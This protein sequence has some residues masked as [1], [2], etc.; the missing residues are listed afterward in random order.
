MTIYDLTEALKRHRVFLIAGFAIIII[1]MLAVTLKFEDGSI[2]WRASQR[3]QSSIQ[4]AVISPETDS[5]TTTDSRNERL[6]SAASLYASLIGTDEAKIEVGEAAG[7]EFEDPI[8]VSVDNDAAVITT[9]VIAPSPEQAIA[10]AQEVFVWLKDKLLEPLVIAELA[11]E[12]TTTTIGLIALDQPF[13]SAIAIGFDSSLDSVSGRLFVQV[14]TELEDELTLAVADNAG[15]VITTSALLSPT[16]S[17]VL[18]LVDADNEVLDTLRTAPPT[19]P[20]LVD[21]VPALSVRLNQGAVRGGTDSATLSQAA[22]SIDWVSGVQVSPEAVELEPT[23]ETEIAVLTAEFGIA[24]I[25]G[26]QGPITMIAILLIGTVLLLSGVVVA[27]SWRNAKAAATDTDPDAPPPPGAGQ[28]AAANAQPA[29][30]QTTA[31]A[32][33]P[34]GKQPGTSTTPQAPV[35][36]DAWDMVNK[37]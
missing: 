6:Q 30:P 12:V 22:I 15:S 14:S 29:S 8:A 13:D 5:L 28:V 3:Y 16:E 18:R 27:E 1:A 25:G 19:L 9:T 21:S 36:D 23:N 10:A 2:G 24:P 26:K 37:P 20:Q 35:A 33:P 7:F 4:I 32:K 31:P 34:K 11:P 17:V